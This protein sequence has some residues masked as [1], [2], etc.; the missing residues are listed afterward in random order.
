MKKE[1]RIN[2]DFFLIAD[3]VSVSECDHVNACSR[4]LWR[5]HYHFSFTYEA[6]IRKKNLKIPD[7][8]E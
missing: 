6:N 3:T 7:F 8:L 2:K 1:V 5:S 4:F